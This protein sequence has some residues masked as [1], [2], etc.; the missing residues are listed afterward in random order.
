MIQKGERQQVFIEIFHDENGQIQTG[1]KGV[2]FLPTIGE[3]D[4]IPMDMTP[5]E[6]IL[7][8]HS[9]LSM[10]FQGQVAAQKPQP[11]IQLARGP[12]ARA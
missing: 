6:A 12:V 3:V 5:P 2:R 1:L 7:A 4:P 9:S 10:I 8:I 11:K